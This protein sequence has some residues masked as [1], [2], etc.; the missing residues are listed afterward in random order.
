MGPDLELN[1]NSAEAALGKEDVTAQVPAFSESKEQKVILQPV[2]NCMEMGQTP[3]S[4][5]DEEDVQVNII[6]N[7]CISFGGKAVEDTCEDLTATECSSSSSFGDTGSGL[8]TASGSAFSDSEV[9]SVLYD[10]WSEPPRL[11]KKKT[12]DHWRRFIRPLMWRCKWIELQL[13]KL[14][15]QA[16]KYEKELAAYDYKKEVEFSRFTMEGFG[17]KSVPISDGIYKNKVMKRKKRKRAEEC[18]LS[19]YVS[20][21]TIFSYYENKNSIHDDCLE[22]FRGDTIKG[23]TDNTEEFNLN[24]MWSSVEHEDNDKSFNDIIQTIDKLLSQVEKLKTGL[25]MWEDLLWTEN[26][27]STR[28]GITPFIE[29]TN[30]PQLEILQENATIVTMELS[31]ASTLPLIKDEVLIQNQVAKEE[32]HDFEDIRNQPGENTKESVE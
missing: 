12:T 14:N 30:R 21:H 6:G 7:G 18:D 4:R 5:G 3:L 19:S 20:N 9:E 8:E 31:T 10:D 29:T 11:R 26:T 25:I 2:T 32:L 27:L 24:D 22:D 13:K 28:E 1:G 17:V 16:L 23:N 15:F